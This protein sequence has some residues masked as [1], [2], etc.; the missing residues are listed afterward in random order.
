MPYVE[1][2]TIHDADSHVMEF[3]DTILEYFPNEHRVAFEPHLKASDPAWIAEMKSRHE[4]PEFVASERDEVMLRK[5]HLA[6]GAF[7]KEDRPRTLD[8]L[9]FTSQL[10]FTTDALDNYGLETGQTNALACEAARAHNRMMVDFCSVDRRLLATGYVPLVDFD[11]APRIA[12]EALEL[13]AK[14]LVIPS[15]CP[16]GH[17]PSHH[18]FEPLW[19][20]AEEA[21]VPILFHVGGEHKM[22]TDYHI[23]GDAPVLDFHGGAENFTSTSYMAIPLSVWQTMSVLIID[24]VLDRHE[25]LKFGAIELGASWVPGWMRFLDSGAAAFARGEDRLKRLSAT[26]SEIVRRQFRVTP[27]PHEPTGWIIENTGPEVCLF[28]SDF[29]HVEGGRNPLKRFGEALE[30]TSPEQQRGFYRDNFI[31][32]M[33]AGLDVS[34]HDHPSVKSA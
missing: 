28:S 23:T 13:G 14:A 17:S 21:G 34:L 15:R 11:Q 4:D 31:D 22:N 19:S 26:P 30:G 1:N 29:P 18:G 16:P 10:V 7:R 32:L 24:G 3:P 5:G 6:L 8:Y 12:L 2:R 20:L 25:N 27:Y 33:G 9:G